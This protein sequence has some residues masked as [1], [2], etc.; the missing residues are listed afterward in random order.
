M[1]WLPDDEKGLRICLLVLTQYTNVTD[2]RDVQTDT[3]RQ[4]KPGSRG[5]NRCTCTCL[6]VCLCVCGLGRAAM[7]RSKNELAS[8]RRH[9]YL[10]EESCAEKIRQTTDA[11]Y[12]IYTS[13]RAVFVASCRLAVLT[14][15]V[16]CRISHACR[17][18]VTFVTLFSVVF[19]MYCQFLSTRHCALH[20]IMS[21]HVVS[22]AKH[23]GCLCS[24]TLGAFQRR[25]YISCCSNRKYGTEP[26]LRV[27][28]ELVFIS[29]C[30][31]SRTESCL[32]LCV[33]LLG[34]LRCCQTTAGCS[35]G[36]H[37][38]WSRCSGVAVEY[39]TRNREVARLDSHPVH[40]VHCK[41]P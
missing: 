40:R 20:V 5:K 39:R 21:Q 28:V 14:G 25:A 6:C 26:C 8:R 23:W 3:A 10:I 19:C 15:L 11:Q 31:Q 32:D 27:W 7:L 36:F 16:F 30:L 22:V 1:V 38:Q 35:A 41:Q 13:R 34:S 24:Q 37:G 9:V 4:H 17:F 18:S 29:R 2:R 33:D 12:G